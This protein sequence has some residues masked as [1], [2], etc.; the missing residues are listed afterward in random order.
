MGSD[1]SD[2]VYREAVAKLRILLSATD[3]RDHPTLKIEDKIRGEKSKSLD[4]LYA[5]VEEENAEESRDKRNMFGTPRREPMFTKLPPRQPNLSVRRQLFPERIR[6]RHNSWHNLTTAQDLGQDDNTVMRKYQS[7]SSHINQSPRAASPS[8]LS[9]AVRDL[10]HRQEIYIEQLEKEAAFCKEQLATILTQVKDVLISNGNEDKLKKQEMFNL[11]KTIE[12]D[13]KSVDKSNNKYQEEN[14]MLKQKLDKCEDDVFVRKLKNE[15]EMLRV[16]EAEAA[17]QVQRSLKVAEQI[18]Q[19]KSE[20]EF[21]VGQLSG[22]VERQQHKIRSLIE[23]QVSKVNE[24]RTAIERRYKEVVETTKDE[25]QK[26]QQEN[27]KLIGMLDK[28]SRSE[29]DAKRHLEER[30]KQLSKIREDTDRR[31]GELQLEIV[32]V[33]AN[34]QSLERDLNMLKLKIEK[35]K[36]DNSMEIERLQSEIGAVRGRI[37]FAEESL[38]EQRGQNLQMVETVAS[39]ETDLISEKHRRENAEKRK[40]EEISKVK[41]EKNEEIEKLRLEKITKEKKLKRDNEQLEDCIRRQRGII[42]QLKSQCQEVTGKFEDSYNDWLKEKHSMRS[43]MSDLRDSVSDLGGQVRMLESQNVEHIKLHQSLLG[44]I[45][46][47]EGTPG[48]TTIKLSSPNK[49]KHSSS[50][51]KVEVI[52]NNMKIKGTTRKKVSAITIERAGKV[53]HL[54]SSVN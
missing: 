20:A 12:T 42:G 39:L 49:V 22:Q 47:L 3:Q 26:S 14:N 4:H 41:Q 33:T 6:G 24:E 34:K 40:I 48:N 54:I 30:E 13:V 27:V 46:Y 17:E 9:P 11:I 2:S 25:L 1:V 31:V 15:V 44:Q 16:R 18:R 7:A 52:S 50:Q 10:I 45:N 19:Q 8:Q 23:E 37:K 29:N 36:S 32:D 5:K 43:E 53:K 35:E 21:E 28:A 38:V 51:N